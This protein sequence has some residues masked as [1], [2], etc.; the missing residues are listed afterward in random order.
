VPSLD[1]NPVFQQAPDAKGN[2][3]AFNLTLAE[4]AGIPTSLTSMSIN[5]ADYTSQI[6]SLFGT[7]SI[8]AGGSITANIGLSNLAV[9]TNVAFIFNGVDAGGLQW[10]QQLSVPFQ[11]F[12]TQLNIA[13]ISNAATGQ[14]AY[15][16]G[17]ILSIY[18]SALGTF[19]ESAYTVPL[20]QYLAGFSATI[21]GVTAPIYY[22]SPSQVNVQ[23]PYETRPGT[24]TL[25]VWTPYDSATYRF[26]VSAAAPGIF[27]F[28]DGSI[29]PYRT[30]SRSAE[31]AMYITGEGGVTP[32]LATGATPAAQATIPSPRLPV[33]VTVGGVAV[34]PSNV[35]F[36][37]IPSGL[38]GVTQI[39]FTVP[40]T[41]PV[42]MQQVVVTIGG[43]SS[44][45]ASLLVTN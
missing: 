38:V 25:V 39:N 29:N 18:G 9:P 32:A 45:P 22:V 13:G 17:M 23:I 19:A 26:N 3:W 37:G 2:S 8:S 14:Q 33:S 36:T 10:S 27:T 43:V 24:A 34:L 35:E 16:P 5:G 42:G 40:S 1:Q 4:E 30:A 28:S 15:A 41:V 21:N 6:P 44:P 7:A 31:I 11:G 20:P 12:Q